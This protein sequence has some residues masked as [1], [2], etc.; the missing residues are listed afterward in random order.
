VTTDTRTPN[1][2]RADYGRK[3]IEADC[4]AD[5]RSGGVDW[6]TAAS[7][8]IADILH[9]VYGVHANY[10]RGEATDLLDHAFRAW[11]CDDE[12]EDNHV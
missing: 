4:G 10:D 2:R 3:A 11:Q 6:F 8:T 12:D 5:L 9:A 7:D 1:E